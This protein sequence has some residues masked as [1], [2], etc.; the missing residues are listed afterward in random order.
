MP[1]VWRSIERRSIS[2][3]WLRRESRV[4]RRWLPSRL[5][6]LASLTA[7][8]RAAARQRA[9]NIGPGVE[10]FVVPAALPAGRVT[11]R[12][13]SRTSDIS[14]AR[15]TPPTRGS[16]ADGLKEGISRTSC[17]RMIIRLGLLRIVAI[18]ANSDRIGLRSLSPFLRGE[19]WGEGPYPRTEPSVEDLC[20]LTR[21]ASHD[22]YEPKPLLRRPC[23]GRHRGL[24]LSPSGRGKKDTALSLHCKRDFESYSTGCSRGTCPLGGLYICGLLAV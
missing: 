23:D 6:K 14:P 20:T 2:L 21:N 15:S 17:S 18:G 9:R 7:P 4:P 12:F 3:P 19:G 8:D 22:V 13:L 16:L 5:A 11:L 10:Y 1:E 24:P